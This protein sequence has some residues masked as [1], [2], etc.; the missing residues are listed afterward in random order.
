V[1]EAEFRWISGVGE[2]KLRDYGESFLDEIKAHVRTNSR[3]T[4]R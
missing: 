2:R 1:S 3:L 4:F